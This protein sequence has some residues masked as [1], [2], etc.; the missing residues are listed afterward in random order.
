MTDNAQQ[1]VCS[2]FSD[3]AHAWEFERI[4][5]SPHYPQSNGLAGHAVQSAKHLLEKSYRKR[6]DIQAAL[7]HLRNLSRA[8]LPSPAQLLFSRH[9]RTFLPELKDRLKPSVC[10]DVKAVLT[11]RKESKAYYDRKAHTL[12]PLQQGQTVRMQ[13]AQGFDKLAVVQG[14]A[15]QPNSYVVRQTVH[16]KPTSPFPCS[17]ACTYGMCRG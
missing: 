1:F 6:S 9:T 16:K 14:L 10:P 11:R 8:D 12:S 13:T 4:R 17:R 15:A 2:I 5:S 7:L 3:F